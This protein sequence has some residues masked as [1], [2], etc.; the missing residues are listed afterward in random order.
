MTSF[1]CFD[2]DK[3]VSYAEITNNNGDMMASFASPA[4]KHRAPARGLYFSKPLHPFLPL[5]MTA[6]QVARAAQ[7][8]L[9]LPR[10]PPPM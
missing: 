7:Q 4:R 9:L 3:D 8:P 1:E 5:F 2:R 10:V 6:P